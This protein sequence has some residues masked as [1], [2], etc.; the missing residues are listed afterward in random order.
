MRVANISSVI[1]DELLP[2]DMLLDPYKPE[3]S[4]T[5]LKALSALRLHKLATIHCSSLG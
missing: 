1:P 5:R 4:G 3:F 2:G